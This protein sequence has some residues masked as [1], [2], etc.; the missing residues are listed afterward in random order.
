MII[1]IDASRYAHKEAT[2]VEWYG[3][4]VIN[5]LIKSVLGKKSDDRIILYSSRSLKFDGEIQKLISENHDR[6]ENKV[7]KLRCFWTLIRLS[8]QMLVKPPDVLFVPSHVLPLFLP[9]NAVITIHDVA[10]RYLRKS[11][12]FLQYHYLNWAT[13]SAVKRATKI[14][15]PSEA[16]KED[17]MKFFNCPK[18]KVEVIYHGFT[19]PSVTQK[20]IDECMQNSEVFNY[21]NIKKD[22][23]YVLFVGRLESKKNLSRLISAFKTFSETFPRHR[24]VL[25]GKR[26]VGF[27]ELIKI[28]K[29]YDLWDKVIMPGYITEEEKAALYKYCSVFAFPSLYEG[30]GFPILE[31]FHYKKPVITSHVS[32]LP[33]IGGDAA[34]YVDPTDT[35]FISIGLEKLVSDEKSVNSLVS[36]GEKRLKMFSWDETA[37][38]TFDV[39]KKYGQ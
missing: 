36:L 1:G 33:E 25:A 20:Q 12:S 30:F 6:F 19:P 14:I 11:Y 10:F 28:V 35:E 24:L 9:K 8:I 23:P 29:Q 26:G 37:R 21:F 5:G 13:K 22:S 16:T 39:I 2:G 27:K 3:Y 17:L 34:Y 31:A 15:A 38:K 32:C 18:D 4:H 7:I